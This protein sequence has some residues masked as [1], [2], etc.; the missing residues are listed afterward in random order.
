MNG[1]D[2]ERLADY[3]RIIKLMS[4]FH[5]RDAGQWDCLRTLFHHDSSVHVMWFTGSG[6]AFVDAVSQLSH[7]EITSK[8]VIAIPVTKFHGTRATAETNAILVT[9]NATQGFGCTTHIRFLDRLVKGRTGWTIAERRSVYDASFIDRAPNGIDTDDPERFPKEYAA[10]AHV[11]T[12]SGIPVHG[13]YPVRGSDAERAI[14]TNNDA[15]L[16]Q[17][18]QT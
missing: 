3:L 12:R 9:E 17:A 5:Y 4:D 7:G 11:L 2:S 16:C 6:D 13:T 14:R 8:H 15:W 1:D 10:L 18:I